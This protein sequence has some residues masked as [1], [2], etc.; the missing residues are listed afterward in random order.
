MLNKLISAYLHLNYFFVL[1]SLEVVHIAQYLLHFLTGWH[2]LR[3]S[4]DG[5][6]FMLTLR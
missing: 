5:R 3:T 6:V 1:H 4:S 2:S